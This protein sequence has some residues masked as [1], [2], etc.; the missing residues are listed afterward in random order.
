MDDIDTL[1]DL[2]VALLAIMVT[3][4]VKSSRQTNF[5]PNQANVAVFGIRRGSTQRFLCESLQ[6][7]RTSSTP[8]QNSKEKENQQAIPD[9]ASRQLS[10][11]KS[12]IEQD[13]PSF[14][15]VSKGSEDGL[16]ARLDGCQPKYQISREMLSSKSPSGPRSSSH[17]ALVCP[18]RSSFLQWIESSKQSTMWSFCLTILG[19]SA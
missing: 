10:P 13:G 3:I 17:S 12:G 6:M 16:H 5:V 15:H 14:C 11:V 7:Q 1:K 8:W 19:L 2:F 18:M 9:T 4:H